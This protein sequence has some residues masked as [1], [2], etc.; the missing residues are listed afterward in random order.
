MEVCSDCGRHTT[1]Y[2]S[3]GALLCDGQRRV[4]MAELDRLEKESVGAR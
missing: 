2:S 1:D 4:E 3:G